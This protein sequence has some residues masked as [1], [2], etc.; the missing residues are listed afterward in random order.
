MNAT[1]TVTQKVRKEKLLTFKKNGAHP[2]GDKPDFHTLSLVDLLKARDLYHRHLMNKA[3][4]VATA[5]GRY[6]IR[7]TDPWPGDPN[8]HKATGPRTLRN[9]EVRPYSWPCLLVFVEKWLSFSDFDKKGKH[10]PSGMI[11][12][13]LYMPDGTLVPI[14]IVE[15]PKQETPL[16]RIAAA[17]IAPRQFL[18]GGLPL[19]IEEQGAQQFATIGCLVTDGH[20]TYALTSRH[21]TGDRGT[22][23]SAIVAGES[24]V[25][26]TSSS[27]QIT[28]KPF[29]EVYPGWPGRDSHL[30]MDIGLVKL[31]DKTTWRPDV[32]KVG[33][34]GPAVDL[35]SD[36][37]TLELIGTKVKAHGAASGLMAG[38]ICAMFYRYKA[39]GGFEYVADFLIGPREDAPFQTNPGDSGA[40]FVLDYP[41]SEDPLH[42][43]DRRPVAVQWGGH[44]FSSNGEKSQSYA[45]A[46]CLSTVLNE[47]DL[48]LIRSWDFELPE[49]WGAVGHYTIANLACGIIADRNLKKL[50]QANLGNI[51]FKLDAISDKNMRGLSTKEDGSLVPLADWPDLVWQTKLGLRGPRS[52]NPEAPNH[53]ADLD[54]PPPDDSKSLLDL[55]RGPH[56]S[57]NTRYVDPDVWLH[58][59]ELFKNRPPR[60]RSEARA[61]KYSNGVL[62]FRIAQIYRNMV[63]FARRRDEIHFVASAGILAHYVGDAGQPLHIS[64]LHHGDP[65]DSMIDPHSNETEPPKNRISRQNAVHAAYESDMFKYHAID[66]QNKLRQSVSRNGLAL[67]RGHKNAAYKAVELMLKTF[68]ILPP[69]DIVNQFKEFSPEDKPKAIANKLWDQFQ[70]QTVE[71]MANSCRYLAMLWESAWK[72]GGGTAAMVSG[73]PIG[74]GKL[75]DLY[76]KRTFLPSCTLDEIGKYW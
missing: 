2:L 71:V 75:I 18:G 23:V 46:T 13:R 56:G 9:S 58:H 11:S 76:K 49:Y 57:V 25:I 70:N 63:E 14:C 32:Y 69:Q 55:C 47:L 15:A 30:H 52:A 41:D 62:P 28:R 5:I 16:S 21:V 35:S 27:K 8:Q 17:P 1:A 64:Y 37:F 12:K 73:R 4:V 19:I 40:T 61:A 68:D 45:M 10:E 7:K 72:E 66:M 31:E 38:V 43:L 60:V 24:K 44:V 42:N 3:G 67:I 53:F 20:S 65:E 29:E 48:D 74:S 34:L 54:E 33:S 36:N 6:L 59:F 50:M 26:G 51:T 22:P 39:M